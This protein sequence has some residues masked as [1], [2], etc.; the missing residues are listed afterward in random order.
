MS[1]SYGVQMILEPMVLDRRT[2]DHFRRW[3]SSLKFQDI[4][5]DQAART[6]NTGDELVLICG[7]GTLTVR[8]EPRL[9][10]LSL[11]HGSGISQRRDECGST[12]GVS[13]SM[14]STSGSS[15]RG[16]ETLME[17]G[18]AHLPLN[19]ISTRLGRPHRPSHTQTRP[20]RN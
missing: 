15:H 13:S 20:S 5:I 16:C 3:S 2:R 6:R 14:P 11:L 7:L 4:L 19:W 12:A 8:S 10:R 17:Q 1:P 18:T 9:V